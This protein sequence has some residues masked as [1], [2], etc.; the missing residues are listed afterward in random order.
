M[1]KTGTYIDLALAFEIYPILSVPH[2]GNTL[3]QCEEE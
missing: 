2:A 3:T 1:I